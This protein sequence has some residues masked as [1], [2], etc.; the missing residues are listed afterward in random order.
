MIDSFVVVVY[1]NEEL[2][3]LDDSMLSST[4]VCFFI[5]GARLGGDKSVRSCMN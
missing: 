4:R 3:A 5:L 2:I 1:L